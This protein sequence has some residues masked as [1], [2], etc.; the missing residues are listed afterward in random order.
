VGAAKA[1]SPERKG[2][3]AEEMPSWRRKSRRDFMLPKI[4]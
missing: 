1:G 4:R 2:T 3:A